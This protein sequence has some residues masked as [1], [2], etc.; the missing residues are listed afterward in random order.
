MS[1]GRWLWGRPDERTPVD[2]HEL[3]VPLSR[4]PAALDGLRVAVVSDLHFG[5]F[6]EAPYARRV[7]E[8]VNARRPDAV[9]LPG[10]LVN[11][12]P[13]Q[14]R[15][16]MP[17]LAEMNAPLGIF[18]CPGNHDHHAGV[19]CMRRLAEQAGIA[20][21]ANQRRVV[22]VN[23]RS[24]AFA[25]LDDLKQGR[26]D[27]RAAL[28]DLAGDCPVVLLGHNPDLA[29]TVPEDLRV[30]LF[31]AGHT[32]GGQICLF[33]RPVM[34]RIR[35]RRYWRGLT[36]GPRCPV[37]TSRGVGMVGLPVRIGSPPEIPILRL[38]SGRGG[39]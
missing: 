35:H 15:R 36:A 13:S 10:D 5:R 26:P 34:T 38:T 11:H 1:P 37:Y 8:L 29:E 22:S 25:G 9:V 4:W 33:G 7:V 28:G 20:W 19:R 32:H 24:L 17:V 30:D 3:D 12:L 6:V 39:L 23:G 27:V 16:C 31:V 2:V 18:A 21:L 14:A